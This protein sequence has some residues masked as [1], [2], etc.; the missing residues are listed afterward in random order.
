MHAWGVNQGVDGILMLSDKNAELC[1]N[2]GVSKESDVMVR[3]SRY[4]MIVKDGVISH[5][6]PAVKPNGDADAANTYA[7]SVLQALTGAVKSNED[8]G[9]A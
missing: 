5:W 1:R 8:C 4:S 7:P 9:C 3:S 2:L 6:F